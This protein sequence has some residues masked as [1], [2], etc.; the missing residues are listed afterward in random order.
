L[1]KI[2]TVPLELLLF[3]LLII[4]YLTTSKTARI[5]KQL[6]L[7]SILGLFL[8]GFTL[9]RVYLPIEDGFHF[10]NSS[11]YFRN[12]HIPSL[13]F[14]F[15]TYLNVKLLFTFE[16]IISYMVDT[17]LYTFINH[18]YRTMFIGEFSYESYINRIE[19]FRF[20]IWSIFLLGF[21]YIFGFFAYLAK[22]K[23]ESLLHILL[24]ATLF[25]NWLL[26]L[27]FVITYPSICNTDFRYFVPSFLILAYIFAKGVVHMS[28]HKWLIYLYGSVIALLTVS[29]IGFL[30]LI[31]Y[32]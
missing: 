32:S 26:I 28:T 14:T 2:S 18:Q 6:F 3:S 12:Q 1:T 27:K 8:L 10:V 16:S 25:I 30:I 5:E 9:L 31:V 23:K 22:L 19:E 20:L 15:F 4:S 29:E 21:L 13:N 24:F 17:S 11:G 7:F